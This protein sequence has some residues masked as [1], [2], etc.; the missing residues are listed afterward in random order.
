[1]SSQ[2]LRGSNHPEEFI[3]TAIGV[4][5][6]GVEGSE[7]NLLIETNGSCVEGGDTQTPHSDGKVLLPKGQPSID[8]SPP[9][10]LSG[11][12][13]SQTQSDLDSLTI[14]PEVKKTTSLPASSK[15]E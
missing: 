8:E 10:A 9:H 15:T 13:W 6:K 11:Q 14:W 4:L 5:E 12:I 1:M 7:A 3:L 2:F